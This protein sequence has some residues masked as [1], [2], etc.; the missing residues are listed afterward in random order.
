MQGTVVSYPAVISTTSVGLA[1]LLTATTPS[2]TLTS[3]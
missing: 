1:R 2:R 3:V